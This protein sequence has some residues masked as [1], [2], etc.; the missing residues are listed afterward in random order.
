MITTAQVDTQHR[1]IEIKFNLE[2]MRKISLML[3]LLFQFVLV[4]NSQTVIKMRKENGVSVIPCKVNGLPLNFIFDTGSEDVSI[5]LTEA[6]FM[7]KNGYLGSKDILGT[8]NFL[9]ANGNINEG[10]IINIREVEIAGLILKDVKAS[11]GKNLKAPLLLG[12]SAISKLGKIQIDLESNTLT[13]IG[14]NESNN[15]L[16]NNQSGDYTR[17][18]TRM[19][20]IDPITESEYFNRGVSK[21]R[22]G[23]SKGAIMD[24]SEA[25][26]INPKNEN[27]YYYRALSKDLMHDYLGGIEDY[28]KIIEINPKNSLAYVYRG[29]DKENIKDY[30]G[31]MEDIN[32]AIAI[33]PKN[34]EAYNIRGVVRNTQ[35]DYQGALVDYNKA[36]ELNPNNDLFYYNR[37]NTKD[38]L[39]DISGALNDYDKAIQINPK[40]PNYYFNRGN[41][42]IELKDFQGALTD[43]DKAIEI[44][45]QNS[46]YLDSRGLVKFKVEDYQ[47]AI[48]DYNEALAIDPNDAWAPTALEI[49]K[50]ALRENEWID[51]RT[52]A[53]G[54]KLFLKSSYVS[55]NESFIKIWAKKE[56]KKMSLNKN[57]RRITY[58]N[59]TALALFE[60]NCNDRKVKIDSNIYY[61]SKGNIIESSDTEG[62][63][64]NA[65]PDSNGEFLLE[66]AC[67]IFNK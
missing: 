19:T 36:I 33:D 4:G 8:S 59:G 37:G 42:K 46:N 6:S 40:Y 56:F 18:S 13:I 21:A 26:K 3:V 14:N 10:I 25:I 60:I 2:L 54:D 34:S 29:L 23:D 63:W 55:K 28:N 58:K 61:D 5:S 65:I 62:D 17:D 39:K 64:E 57:G 15:E 41:T 20:S 22:T 12:Q 11:I 45:P 32:N 35:K 30:H 27:A 50:Q 16:A 51:V 67:D 31:A 47:G 48:D 1:D 9:D 49:A 24:L 66:K 44:N 7:L 43:Y 38:S 53:N 52:L